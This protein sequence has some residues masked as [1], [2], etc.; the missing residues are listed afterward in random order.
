MAK[1][2]RKLM[3]IF[4]G[5]ATTDQRSVFGSLAASAPAF[6]TDPETIQSLGNWSSGWFAAIVAG[7][8]PAI[9][10]MNSMAFVFAYQLA[11][12][13][14]S[15]VAEWNSAT[16]YYIGSLVSDGNGNIYSS[17]TD[18]NLNHG[19]TSAANWQLATGYSTLAID[20]AVTP[21]YTLSSAS[22]RTLD[23]NTANGFCTIALPSSPPAGYQVTVKDVGGKASIS[24]I[25]LSN[26]GGVNIEGVAANFTCEV[27]YGTWT[28]ICDGTNWWFV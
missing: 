4:G 2:A 8:N 15:G 7:A 27:D 23:V 10:D 6:S 3:Q 24:T 13:F 18:T 28:L 11:Y 25:Q 26:T 17:I 12:L 19:L 21:I 5:T 9:E 22:R 16:T 20:P 14:Q 1:L